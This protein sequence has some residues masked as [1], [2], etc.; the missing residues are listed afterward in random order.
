[1]NADSD[2]VAENLDATR[3]FGRHQKIWTP[4]VGWLEERICWLES[5][6]YKHSGQKNE[7]HH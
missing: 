1:M 6:I 2:P 4:P 5:C 3:K 7:R